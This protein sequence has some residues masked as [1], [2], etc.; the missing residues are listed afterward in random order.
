MSYDKVKYMVCSAGSNYSMCFPKVS[1]A[2]MAKLS[3]NFNDLYDL[4]KCRV[5]Y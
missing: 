4:Y 5:V 3:L 1:T 2:I